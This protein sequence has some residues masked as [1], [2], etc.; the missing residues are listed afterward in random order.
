MKNYSD[1][2]KSKSER[3]LTAKGYSFVW[4]CI[5][6]VA[7]QKGLCRYDSNLKET[8]EKLKKV[9]TDLLIDKEMSINEIKELI[10]SRAFIKE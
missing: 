7:D 3:T 4:K 1:T 6:I 2:I 5:D 9:L 8:K 10:K